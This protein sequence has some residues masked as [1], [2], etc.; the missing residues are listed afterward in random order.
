MDCRASI[1]IPVILKI[2]KLIKKKH[3]V[4]FQSQKHANSE[5]GKEEKEI[6]NFFSLFYDQKP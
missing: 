4:I 6:M 5:K 1:I 2:K 3:L